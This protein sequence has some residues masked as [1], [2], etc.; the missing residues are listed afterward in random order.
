VLHPGAGTPG[1]A[2]AATFVPAAG[3][4][5]EWRYNNVALHGLSLAGCPFALNDN[6]TIN[7]S[8]TF[9]IPIRFNLFIS[10]TKVHYILPPPKPISPLPKT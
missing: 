1:D 8:N 10:K 9:F 3:T 2:V 5:P 4:H 6:A 7:K